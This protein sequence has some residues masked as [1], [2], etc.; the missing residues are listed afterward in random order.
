MTAVKGLQELKFILKIMFC[1]A[2]WHHR[3]MKMLLY[4]TAIRKNSNGKS[5]ISRHSAIDFPP[6]RIGN[7]LL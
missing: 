5:V 4:L 6:I 3:R 7:E 2:V 1:C